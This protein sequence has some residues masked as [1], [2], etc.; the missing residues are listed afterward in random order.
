MNIHK[1]PCILLLSLSL[2]LLSRTSCG[3][4]YPFDQFGA[5]VLAMS[6]PSLLAGRHVEREEEKA[7]M[8]CKHCSAVA[9]ALDCY[10]HC[11][12]HKFKMQHCMGCSEENFNSIPARPSVMGR[13]SERR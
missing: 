13:Q 1:H 12:P 5:T 3:V 9:K 11:L 7:L 2:C 10:Q 8:S 4:Q 6:V